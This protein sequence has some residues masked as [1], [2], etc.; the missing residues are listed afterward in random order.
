MIQWK[1]LPSSEKSFK[2]IL[3]RFRKFR[4]FG[5]CFVKNIKAHEN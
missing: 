2:G 4:A 1:A 3:D 5:P